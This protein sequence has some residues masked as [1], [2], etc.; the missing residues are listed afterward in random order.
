MHQSIYAIITV[1]TNLKWLH[2][3]SVCHCR[4]TWCPGILFQCSTLYES[5]GHVI[6]IFVNS[7]VCQINFLFQCTVI[8]ILITHGICA[9]SL[10]ASGLDTLLFV[11]QDF[12][13]I[14]ISISNRCEWTIVW[15]IAVAFK[16]LVASLYHCLIS[17]TIIIKC[18]SGS[19]MLDTLNSVSLIICIGNIPCL[20][21]CSCTYAC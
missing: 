11:I 21:G 1:I 9:F 2:C 7:S 18:I 5:S 14:S 17:E 10:P 4:L 3:M 15:C 20:P 16:S 19:T 13:R 6:L 12:L 8:I